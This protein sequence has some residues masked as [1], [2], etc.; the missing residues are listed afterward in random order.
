MTDDGTPR[1]ARILFVCTGNLCRSAMAERLAVVALG[2][3]SGVGSP[4]PRISSAGT[5][6]ADGRPMHPDSARALVALGGDPSDFF[7][8]RLVSEHLEDVDLV[9]TAT[10]EHRAQVL[11]RRPDLMRRT[12]TILEAAALV[13]FVDTA[14][15]APLMTSERTR[16]LATALD[17]ARSRRAGGPED[18]LTDP[19]DQPAEVH[20]AVAGQI[21][22][23]LQPV[24]RFVGPA[25]S[26]SRSAPIPGESGFRHAGSVP[27]PS[28]EGPGRRSSA[29]GVG[30]T[31]ASE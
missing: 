5:A 23:S 22:R 21:A 11:G 25:P 14:D 19:I 30:A 3:Q 6:A 29:R 12:F 13:P 15:V 20:A 17:G 18:D 27:N 31:G 9:L 4:G 8:R 26:L 24:L 7:S 1:T 2:A 16:L 10:R 28:T